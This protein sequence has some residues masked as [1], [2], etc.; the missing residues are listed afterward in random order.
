M[1]GLF[2]KTQPGRHGRRSSPRRCAR[3]ELEGLEERLVLSTASNAFFTALTTYRYWI[4]YAPSYSSPTDPYNSNPSDAHI[5]SDL[6]ALHSEGWRGL[7]TYTL[8]GTYADIPKIAKA[9]GFQW[10]VAGVYDPTNPTEVAA[11]SAPNVL[12]YTDAYVV[13]NEGLTDGRYTYSALTAAISTVQQTTGKPV[14][15]SEP[16][17]AYYTGSPYAQQLL[18]LGDWLFPNIDYFL[19][20]GKPSTPQFMWTNVSYVYQYML[21]KQTTAGPVV[22][23]EV[24]Y[25]TAGGPQASDANQI[26]WYGSEAVPNTVGGKPFYFVWGEAFDQPWKITINSYEPYM[27]LHLLDNPDGTVQPK[28]IIAQLQADYTGT[29]G[30]TQSATPAPSPAPTFPAP[31]TLIAARRVTLG[32]GEHRLYGDALVFSAPL[33][34]SSAQNRHLYHVNE[35]ASAEETNNIRV[36]RAKYNAASRTVT[37]VLGTPKLPPR[38]SVTVSGLVGA[39]GAPIPTFKTRL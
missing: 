2:L 33:D 23:K 5:T 38:L 20:N 14:S 1:R 12:Q 26:T 22:A 17:G 27:G 25:P 31:P 30:S 13:G 6:N 32:R 19:W 36:L 28:P 37:L 24:F 18:S 34:L 10:V 39:N 11:A 15:T 4:D 7:V 35:T 29:Y 16:G 21:Q 3:P 9:V 8:Q